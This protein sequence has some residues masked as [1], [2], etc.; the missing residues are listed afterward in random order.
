LFELACLAAGAWAGALEGAAIGWATGMM[1]AAVM[2]L[3]LSV[4]AAANT[5]SLIC[6]IE[7][8]NDP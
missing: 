7:P 3:P 2:L 6:F 8:I 1:V 4:P 5:L